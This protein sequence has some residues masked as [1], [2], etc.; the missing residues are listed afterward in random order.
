MYLLQELLHT[1]NYVNLFQLSIVQEAI[2]DDL[3][4][5]NDSTEYEF[6]LDTLDTRTSELRHRSA[7]SHTPH[8]HVST[9]PHPL[10][11][12]SISAPITGFMYPLLDQSIEGGDTL[13]RRTPPPSYEAVVTSQYME[14]GG[15]EYHRK[16][17]D[18]IDPQRTVPKSSSTPLLGGYQ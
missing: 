18:G 3:D 8:Q 14:S 5:L 15:F 13:G 10:V 7:T 17:E 9:R 1:H 4:P 6:G 11:Q 16:T 12:Y 2:A